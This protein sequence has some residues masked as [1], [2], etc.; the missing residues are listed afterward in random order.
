MVLANQ[1]NHKGN[2]SSFELLIFK[3]TKS[4]GTKFRLQIMLVTQNNIS[5]KKMILFLQEQ[6]RPLESHIYFKMHR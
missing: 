5:C 3:M 1:L 6:G 2:I 4:R